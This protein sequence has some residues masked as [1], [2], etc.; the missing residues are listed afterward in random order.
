[1]EKE[2][3]EHRDCDK[4]QRQ[5]I[6]WLYEMAFEASGPAK[7]AADEGALEGA[8]AE[9]KGL[10]SVHGSAVCTGSSLLS[11]AQRAREPSGACEGSSVSHPALHA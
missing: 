6:S 9:S 5:L 8:R 7:A 3:R 11:A 10:T 1:M 4:R 2:L